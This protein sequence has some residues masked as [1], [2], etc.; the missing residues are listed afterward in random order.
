MG[1]SADD[2]PSLEGQT[3]VVT[4]ANSGIGLVTAR[5]LAKAGATVVMG[6][7]DPERG[8]AALASVRADAPGADAELGRLDLADLAS[9]RDFAGTVAAEHPRLDGLVN[10]AGV[11]A[12]P[13]S[14]TADGFEIQLGTNHLGHFALTGLLLGSLR[15]ADAPR[16]VTVASAAHRMGSIDFE[17]LQGER[18]YG[19]WRRYGQSKLANLLFAFELQRHSDAE[20]WNILSAAAHPG[21]ASTHLQTSG[22]GT[23]GGIQSLLN[24]T[25]GKLGNLLIAQS[26]EMGALP[27]LYAATHPG[28]P[29]G[30]YVGPSGP[31]EARGHPQLVSTSRAARSEAVAARLWSTSEELTSVSFAA[32][33]A[34]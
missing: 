10:N 7:R 19:R 6:C 26:D 22:P 8:E 29:P 3:F 17:D 5:E 12:T 16:V 32:G 24:V 27:T 23:G 28:M 13:R 33:A 9:V 25:L 14:E 2:I 20:G 30:G 15:A 31:G 11:M 34:V 1:W 18:S 21:Y 4:G